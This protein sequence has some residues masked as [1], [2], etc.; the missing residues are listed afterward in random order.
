MTKGE[1]L[2]QIGLLKQYL[3]DAL[4]SF[5]ECVTRD[6]L[7]KAAMAI[8]IHMHEANCHTDAKESIRSL[9]NTHGWL[10]DTKSL[11]YIAVSYG[12]LKE[13]QCAAVQQQ[14]DVL[15][16]ALMSQIDDT[17]TPL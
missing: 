9:I 10:E 12:Y 7:Q 6:Q 2:N 8:E 14:C 17:C 11:A 13:G 16:A 4:M 15:I 5:P 3:L 1:I